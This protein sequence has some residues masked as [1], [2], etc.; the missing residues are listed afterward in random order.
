MGG[1]GPTVR[2]DGKC[3]IMPLTGS[4]TDKYSQNDF[5]FFMKEKIPLT[6]LVTCVWWISG[7]SASMDFVKEP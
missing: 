2:Q 5:F 6:F 4:A 7:Y 3:S 1:G